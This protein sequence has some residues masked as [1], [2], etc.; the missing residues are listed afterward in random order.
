[1]SFRDAEIVRSEPRFA[2]GERAHEQRIRVL[3]PAAIEQHV[4]EDVEA[5]EE[6]GRVR[7]AERFRLLERGAY[8]LLGLIELALA[9]RRVR[10]LHV[11]VPDGMLRRGH[12]RGRQQRHGEDGRRDGGTDRASH[13]K[14]SVSRNHGRSPV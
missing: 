3:V 14:A 5:Q 13:G 10:G 2:D 4:A 7:P 1:M 9:I 12:G 11:A 6:L 8:R